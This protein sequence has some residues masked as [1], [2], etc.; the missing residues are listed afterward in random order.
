MPRASATS[1]PIRLGTISMDVSDAAGLAG[2]RGSG[3]GWV[4]GAVMIVSVG[5]ESMG[6]SESAAGD[7]ADRDGV[8]DDVTDPRGHRRHVQLWR[9]HG[10]PGRFACFQGA[11][12]RAV[13]QHDPA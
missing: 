6:W 11:D 10:V 1:A 3:M 13:A 5:S 8:Q 4:G 7:A 9:R 2:L 12:L